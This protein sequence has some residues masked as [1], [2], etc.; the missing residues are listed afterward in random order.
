MP[1]L[2]IKPNAGSGNK[3]IIQDQA[4]GA[5]MTT[6]DS[7][8]TISATLDN[9]TQD[10]I[11]RLGTVTTGTIKNTIHSDATF[12][13]GHVV[14]TS[15]AGDN[16][17]SGDVGTIGSTNMQDSGIEV[18]HVTAL[19]SSNSFIVVEFFSSNFYTQSAASRHH[20]DCT[21]RTVSNSTYTAGESIV[22]ASQKF[23]I[24]HNGTSAFHRQEFW[25]MHCGTG[26]GMGMPD[27]KSSWAAGDT[28][29]FRLWGKR[30]G[31]STTVFCKANNFWNLSV[32]EVVK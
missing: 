25:R 10:G 28:L 4:G 31:G 26:T 32:M 2:T 24:H 14:K 11:T 9:A 19:T 30:D 8:A 23:Y 18:S 12:P 22:D 15:V 7:G 21:M 27:T 16:S 6:A 17:T 5:V 3:V 13:A 1:D 29:Y 20:F